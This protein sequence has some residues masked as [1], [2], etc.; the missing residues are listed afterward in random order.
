M[1]KAFYFVFLILALV[2]CHS[3]EQVIYLQDFENG[4]TCPVRPVEDFRLRIGDRFNAI[5]T[6]SKSETVVARYN[7]NYS[8]GGV[9]SANNNNE[10]TQFPYTIAQDGQCELPG[11]GRVALAGLTRMEAQEKVQSLF[12]N[13]VLKDAVVTISVHDQ[14][15]TLL[16]DTRAGKYEFKRDN[17]TILELLG[18]AG[19][20]NV[21]AKRYKVI[22]FRTENNTTKSYV[23]DL[24]KKDFLQ[25]PVYNLMPGDV[26]YVEPNKKQSNNYYSA[27][28]YLYNP[29][30]YFSM[31]SF[32]MSLGILIFK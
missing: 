14:F 12:R 29:G 5:V 24:R 30:S 22:V 13:G 18:Q 17:M 28:S 3:Q 23:L 26:V 6:S 8:Q 21:T 20:L 32:L 16:G 15:V 2:S 11:I 31:I 9:G 1:K 4:Q 10:Y 27:G 25:S 19:D 7:Y